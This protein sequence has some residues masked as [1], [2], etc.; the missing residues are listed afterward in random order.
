[1]LILHIIFI[2]LRGAAEVH[3]FSATPLQLYMVVRNFTAQLCI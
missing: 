3:L 2:L 1:M